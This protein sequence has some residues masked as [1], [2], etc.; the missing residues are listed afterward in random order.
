MDVYEVSGRVKEADIRRFVLQF[1]AAVRKDPELGPIFDSR[2]ADRWDAHLGRMVDFWSSVLLASGRYSGNPLATHAAIPGLEPRHYDRWLD[3]FED[4]LREV[5]DE[6][7]A[8]DVLARAR[9]MRVVLESATHSSVMA[10][11]SSSSP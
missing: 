6:R 8:V 4:T 1:Y 11:H 7:H 10:S 5:L 9:R 2:I 3:L